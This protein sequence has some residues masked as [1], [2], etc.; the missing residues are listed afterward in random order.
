[1]AAS[2]TRAQL[3]F[4]ALASSM[5]AFVALPATIFTAVRS[6]ASFEEKMLVVQ[7]VTGATER[8]FMELTASARVMGATTRFSAQE[9]AEG[10]TFLARAGLSSRNAIGALP[11]TLNLAQVGLLGLGEAADIA[12]NVL[13]PFFGSDVNQLGRIVN[14][15]VVVSNR[16]NT[17]VRQMG[18][19]MVYAA[20]LAAQLG[21]SVEETAA[22]I[23]V[24]GDS[25]IQGS[26]AG[27][28][29]R[30]SMVRL[31]KPTSEAQKE[32]KSLGLTLDE[33]NPAKA[34]FTESIFALGEA[35]DELEDQTDKGRI[36]A[37]IFGAR[38]VGVALSLVESREKLEDLIEAQ[39]TYT[40][41]AEE[42][43]R[44]MDT[45]LIGQFKSLVSAIQE[46]FLQMGDSGLTG[47]LKNVVRWMTDAIRILTGFHDATEET[48]I[49]VRLLAATVKGLTIAL[50]AMLGIGVIKFFTQMAVGIAQVTLAMAG[51]EM[52]TTR[53]LF[54]FLG[55]AAVI[56]AGFGLGKTLQR[57]TEL[58]A[59]AADTLAGAWN[60]AAARLK[61]SWAIIKS[62]GADTNDALLQMEEEQMEAIK[63]MEMG[64]EQNRKEF[65]KTPASMRTVANSIKQTWQEMVSDIEGVID[66][67]IGFGK[68]NLFK[69]IMDDLEAA[70]ERVEDMYADLEQQQ[71]ETQ[72]GMSQMK[73]TGGDIASSLANNFTRLTDT[74][75]TFQDVVRGLTQDLIQ[76]F[77]R[78]ALFNLLA[79]AFGNFQF[80]GA[81]NIKA[82]ATGFHGN[83]TRPTVFL[84]GEAGSERVDITPAGEQSREMGMGGRPIVM[85]VYAQDAGS[86]QRSRRQ[87]LSELRQGMRASI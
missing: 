17:S 11:A 78:T 22:G 67:F 87:I 38:N 46:A 61:A 9:A 81:P 44:L 15:M 65:E 2:A 77:L 55:I 76:M 66:S 10:L 23:G 5:A 84:A 48:S 86:F 24:L 4:T 12:T 1:M 34:G 82:A 32:L 59:D 79:P 20:P 57:D 73:V 25:G 83:V 37:T 47:A 72:D 41:E 31:I 56:T 71:E 75:T 62:G 64:W 80:G 16:A 69:S 60:V 53:T 13:T 42:L 74:A 45:S 19:A 30:Q 50:A 43:A 68:E 40:N 39:E 33:V 3:S 35:F 29:L 26:M 58:G 51:L 27:A 52:S 7:G 8:E 49:G 85:N 14:N 21:V 63:I 36:A 28:G 18:E 6:I 54:A 70:T